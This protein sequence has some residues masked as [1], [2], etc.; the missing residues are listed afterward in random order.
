VKY[1]GICGISVIYQLRIAYKNG[2]RDLWKYPQNIEAKLLQ[3][4]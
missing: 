3:D 2:F 4:K 1:N